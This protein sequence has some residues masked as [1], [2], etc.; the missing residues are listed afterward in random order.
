[1]NDFIVTIVNKTISI[2]LCIIYGYSPDFITLNSEKI[3]MRYRAGQAYFCE[4]NQFII[5]NEYP[6]DLVK[7]ICK[8]LE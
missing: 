2:D 3:F 4:V 8:E 6:E 5:F 1:M 7:V